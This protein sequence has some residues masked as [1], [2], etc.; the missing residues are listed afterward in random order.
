[1]QFKA[2]PNAT[3]SEQNK[4][5][6]EMIDINELQTWLKACV[7]GEDLMTMGLLVHLII[8]SD[9]TGDRLTQLQSLVLE[10]GFSRNR[11]HRRLRSLEE[12]GAIR[13]TKYHR[14]GIGIKIN[15]CDLI[16]NARRNQGGT[17]SEHKENADDTLW[18]NL[19]NMLQQAA[20]QFVANTVNNENKLKSD[21]VPQQFGTQTVANVQPIRND[22]GFYSQTVGDGYCESSFQSAIECE[23]NGMNDDLYKDGIDNYIYKA[24][25][26]AEFVNQNSSSQKSQSGACARQTSNPTDSNNNINNNTNTTEKNKNIY[27]SLPPGNEYRLTRTGAHENQDSKGDYPASRIDPDIPTEPYTPPKEPQW[28]PIV[29]PFPRNTKDVIDAAAVRGIALKEED[30]QAFMDYNGARG[31]MLGGAMIADWRKLLNNWKKQQDEK[32]LRR[33]CYAGNANNSR[34]DNKF[35]NKEGEFGPGDA[36]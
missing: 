8:T 10:T 27:I 32:E 36:F 25:G 18:I 15:D 17:Q 13:R 20:N 26:T 1:M 16:G 21:A 23:M 2:K 22:C 9:F 29:I 11:L 31:W 7:G 30:A 6:T 3:Q 33:K 4:D 5:T 14:R 24:E 34:W 12:R 28:H 19:K 35:V